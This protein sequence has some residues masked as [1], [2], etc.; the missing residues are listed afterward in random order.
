[1]TKLEKLSIVLTVISVVVCIIVIV[2]LIYFAVKIAYA[3]NLDLIEAR[4]EYDSYQDQRHDNYTKS[5]S[6]KQY[7]EIQRIQE[8]EDARDIVR[9]VGVTI[10][11]GI[12][13]AL[14]VKYLGKKLNM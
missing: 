14:A 6:E 9:W 3:D 1:M 5:A 13:I 4:S 7:D 2:A 10:I 8:L 11:G 12:G